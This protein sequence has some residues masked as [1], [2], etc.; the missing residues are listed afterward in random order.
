MAFSVI[1]SRK[2]FL[3]VLYLAVDPEAWGTGLARQILNYLRRHAV[4][5]KTQMELWVIA[6]NSRAIASYEN[7]GWV[8]TS[9]V[10][11]RNSTGRAERRYILSP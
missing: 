8:P 4:K 5:E 11:V 2:N 10:E 3:E 1:I 7:A 6:D 9:D